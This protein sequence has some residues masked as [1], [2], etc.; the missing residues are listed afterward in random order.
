MR[1]VGL[2]ALESSSADFQT[3]A[4]P[5]QLPTQD[6]ED[7]AANEKARCRG[8]TGLGR[9]SPQTAMVSPAQILGGE[10]VIPLI[11]VASRIGIAF[12]TQTFADET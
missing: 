5:S 4:N 10:R 9:W 2:E 8:D 12:G 1:R 3:A 11:Q 6:R 7:T